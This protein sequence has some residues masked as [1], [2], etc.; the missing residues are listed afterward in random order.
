MS[1]MLVLLVISHQV[2]HQGILLI[3]TSFDINYKLV[4]LLLCYKAVYYGHIC[5]ASDYY[6][7]YFNNVPSK[8][9]LQIIANFIPQARFYLLFKNRLAE[10]RVLE[11]NSDSLQ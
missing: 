5:L 8:Q 6:C 10:A 2:L 4:I 7:E 1:Y 11:P 3:F 9:L